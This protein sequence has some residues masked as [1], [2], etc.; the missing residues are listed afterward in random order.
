MD[1]DATHQTAM[2]K[3]AVHRWWQ[4]R[5]TIERRS[6]NGRY[7]FN[8][9][10]NDLPGFLTAAV[11]D[12]LLECDGF[13]SYRVKHRH[14]WEIASVVKPDDRRYDIAVHWNCTTCPDMCWGIATKATPPPV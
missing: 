4:S 5:R 3:S 9:L 11:E 7:W 1:T 13:G 14:T 10:S 8:Y 6:S 2:E 12:G